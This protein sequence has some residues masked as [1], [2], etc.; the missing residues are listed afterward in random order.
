MT[1]SQFIK[2]VKSWFW[3]RILERTRNKSVYPLL[4]RSYWHYKFFKSK[5]N[6]NTTCYFTALPNP[7]AGIGHQ[8]ANWIAGY[9]FAKQFGLKFAHLPF[10]TQKWEDF[11]GFGE[12][13]MKVS[14]LVKS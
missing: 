13:E 1:I 10:S 4:Y 2:K 5:K 6:I 11:L 9:W 12:N 7:G 3:V 8:L 14:E